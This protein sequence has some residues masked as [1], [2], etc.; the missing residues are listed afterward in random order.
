MTGLQGVLKSPK[1]KRYAD[2]VS[3][4]KINLIK[5]KGLKI[6][7]LGRLLGKR[8]QEIKHLRAMIREMEE[9]ATKPLKGNG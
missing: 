8:N 9:E 6:N 3:L 7:L 2:K 1:T 4:K 5:D